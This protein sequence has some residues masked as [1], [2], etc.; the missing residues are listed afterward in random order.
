MYSCVYSSIWVNLKFLEKTG[1]SSLW[2]ANGG[3]WYGH[4]IE[5]EC[6]VAGADVDVSV[7]VAIGV[8]VDIG[9]GLDVDVAIVVYVILN[10]PGDRS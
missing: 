5:S 10:A 2:L 1:S 4:L 9:V 7:A 3:K 8:G 6:A